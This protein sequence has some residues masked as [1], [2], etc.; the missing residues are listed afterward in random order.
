MLLITFL[1]MFCATLVM[2]KSVFALRSEVLVLMILV[3][4]FHPVLVEYPIGISNF[5]NV[6]YAGALAITTFLTIRHGIRFS[7]ETMLICLAWISMIWVTIF[8]M[9]ASA[10]LPG[11]EL[12]QIRSV[13]DDLIVYSF[14]GAFP[15]WAAFV[16][17]SLTAAFTVKFF[18]GWSPIIQFF[19]GCLA[20]QV[21]DSLIFF[22]FAFWW[23]DD[24]VQVMVV[25]LVVKLF[26]SVPFAALIE[27]EDGKSEAY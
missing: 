7:I 10:P 1:I 16:A 12:Q 8:T 2:A 5:G 9:A 22:P 20:G 13:I 11:S 19:A 15:S 25:G 3:S 21:V 24:W 23:V 17:A 14:P 18:H 27:I 6:W 4:F 26:M